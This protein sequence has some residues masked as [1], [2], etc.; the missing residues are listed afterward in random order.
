MRERRA[1]LKPDTEGTV[2]PRATSGVPL[3]A[4]HPKQKAGTWSSL[5]AQ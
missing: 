5:L 1:L 4:C 2:P 3:W